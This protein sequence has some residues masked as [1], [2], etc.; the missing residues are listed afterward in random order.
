MIWNTNLH[1]DLA[2]RPTPLPSAFLSEPFILHI[3]SS[4]CNQMNDADPP[5]RQSNHQR[6]LEHHLLFSGHLYHALVDME[7]KFFERVRIDQP[8]LPHHYLLSTHERRFFQCHQ[9]EDVF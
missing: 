2:Q 1:G 8:L 5:T 6:Y 3:S 4:Q 7:T 9:K